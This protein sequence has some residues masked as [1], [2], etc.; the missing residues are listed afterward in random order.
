MLDTNICIFMIKH[1]PNVKSAFEKNKEFGIAISTIVLSELEYG[2]ARSQ[3][4]VKNKNTLINF[5]SNVTVLDFDS[6]AAVEYGNIC[7]DLYRKGTPVGPKDMLIGAHAK[8][9]GLTLVTNNIREFSR[10]NGLTIEDWSE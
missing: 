1:I 7:A 3:F 10:I 2:I 5:L 4:P 9:A 6:R 8:S